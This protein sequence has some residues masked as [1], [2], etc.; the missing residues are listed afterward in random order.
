M[1]DLYEKKNTGKDLELAYL[2]GRLKD[3]NKE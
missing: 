1:I 3:L 2:K